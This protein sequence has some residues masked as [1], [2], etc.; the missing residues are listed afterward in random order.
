MK[1]PTS[2]DATTDNV[3]R[4]SR[5]DGPIHNGL[6]TPTQFQTDGVPLVSPLFSHGSPPAVGGNVAP[7]R[8]FSVD[9]VSR[10]A[11]PHVLVE[12]LEGLPT[13]AH[14]DPSASIVCPRNVVRV[15]TPGEH[16]PPRLMLGRSRESVSRAAFLATARTLPSRSEVF[17]QH[18]RY[19]PARA[20]NLDDAVLVPLPGQV[21]K[22]HKVPKVISGGHHRTGLLEAATGLRPS[23]TEVTQV[24]YTHLPTDTP[25]LNTSR[26]TSGRGVSKHRP[27]SVHF[28]RQV[29]AP[30]ITVVGCWSQHD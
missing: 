4:E 29:H 6:G 30:E 24:S 11:W 16:R 18:L 27:E 21:T 12:R 14:F 22:H 13:G 28:G 3:G 23:S 17:Q 19:A 20:S 10:R 7:V 2:A 25:D 1:L 9:G 15:V 5:L 26:S 8:V